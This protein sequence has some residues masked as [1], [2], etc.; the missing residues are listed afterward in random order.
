[1]AWQEE[2]RKLDEELASGRITAENYRIRRDAVLASAAT[3]PQGPPPSAA[4]ATAMIPPVTGNTPPPSNADRTQVV[5]TGDAADKTQIVSGNAMSNSDR[6]Q[7]VRPGWN[8][9]QPQGGWGQQ[10]PGVPQQQGVRGMPPS[11]PRGMPQQNPPQQQQQQPQQQGWES[12]GGDTGTPWGGSDFPPLNYGGGNQDWI[13]QGPEVFGE[14]SGGSKKWLIIV[15]VVVVVLGL[16]AGGYFLFFNKTSQ[17]GPG[18]STT[19]STSAPTTKP[20]PPDPLAIAQL[21]G[22]PQDQS[23]IQNFNDVA[24]AQLLTQSE[25]SAYQT[26]GASKAHL[27]TS[28]L[29]NGDHLWVMTVQVNSPTSAGTAVT[30]LVALQ[31]T[32]GMQAFTGPTPTGVQATQ[33]TAA[34][35]TPNTIRA[36]YASKNVVVRVQVAGPSDMSTVTQEFNQLVAAQVKLLAPN[37]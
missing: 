29:P 6:T 24:Q 19:T 3:S 1:L 18:Q 14:P 23:G 36:H 31:Q 21:S 27:A 16:G 22:T 17:A 4:E 8:Q 30:T 2:L 10:I 26:E 32:N 28:T 34:S 33:I 35:D 11:P 25:L 9:Q 5:S 37:A 20:K 7:A 13:K 15:I 12:G